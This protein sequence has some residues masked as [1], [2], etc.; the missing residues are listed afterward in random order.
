M[1]VGVN[2]TRQQDLPAEIYNCVGRRGEFCVGSD[3]FDDA[4][5]RVDS[6]IL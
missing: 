3:F 4:I 1:V 6:R 2:K 5:F